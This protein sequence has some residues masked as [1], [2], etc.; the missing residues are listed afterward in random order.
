MLQTH[1]PLPRRGRGRVR[2]RLRRATKFCFN[3]RPDSFRILYHFVGP[4]PQNAPA[5]SFHSLG[6]ARVG[7]DLKSVLFSVDLDDKL[8]R[9][10]G[11]VGK[12]GSNRMLTAEFDAAQSSI[13]KQL[14]ANA[15]SATIVAPEFTGSIDIFVSHAP[16]P[17]SPPSGERSMK[18]QAGTGQDDR[19]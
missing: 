1:T 5:F 12:V 19:S 4:E 15:L 14:P 16:H 10:A 3:R 2:G 6:S 9:D 17:A 11:E 8:P 13:P 18:N 7:I